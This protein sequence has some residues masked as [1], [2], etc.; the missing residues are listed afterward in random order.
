MPKGRSVKELREWVA[1]AQ[2]GDKEAFSEVVKR[3]QD[4]A[5]AIA[6]AMLDD[7]GLAQDAAQEAF[8]AAY[9]NLTALREPAAFPGWFRRIVIKHSDR[10]RRSRKPS[11][12]LDDSMEISATVPDPMRA[13]AASE[14]KNEIHN[15]IAELPAIQRQIITLFYLRDYSQKEI[16]GF[17]ELPVSTIKK[18]LFT[19]RK[20]LKG[21]LESMVETQIQ[22]NRPSQSAAFADE[23]Q[24]LLALR[25]G[26]FEGFKRMVKRQPDLLEMRF[27]A[28]VTRERHYWPLGGTVLH[29]AVVTGDEALL[30]FLLSCKVNVEPGDRDGWTPL[31]TAVWTGQQAII[32]CLLAAGAGPNATTKNGH[33][34]LHFAA[35][36]NYPEA[37]TPLLEAGARIDLADKNGRTPMD[38]AVLKN[39]QSVIDQLV[40]HGAEQVAIAPVRERCSAPA[41]PM[42]ETGIKVIDLF[43]PLVRGRHNGILTPHTNVGSLVLLTELMLRLDVLYGS[44]T[45][46]LGLDDEN[47]TSRDMQL[48]IG[49]AGINDVVSLI[50]GNV[51]DSVEQQS[52]MLEQ[53]LA[54]AYNLR[55]QGKE[56]LFLVLN[57]IDLYEAFEAR[58]A[59]TSKKDAGITTLYFCGY[60]AGAEPEPLAGLDAVIALDFGRAKQGLYPAVDPINSRSCLLQ[61][62]NVSKAQRE[63]AAEARRLLRRY[64]DLQPIIESRGIDLL[65]KD[66]DR[67]IVERANRLQRFLTQPFH[68]TEPWTNLPGVHVPL[69]ETLE[70]CRAIL[71]GECDDVPEEAFYFVGNLEA[72][73]GKAKVGKSGDVNR[74][75]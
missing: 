75:S 39:A 55:D 3:C 8:I 11:Y 26:D 54:K 68:W 53:A 31:H 33:T 69:A 63:I 74:K 62:G 70:G 4:M 2:L 15:A 23:V 47:F 18:H 64:Q 21:R 48:L 20:K 13:L 7:T 16:E 28:P 27:K 60:T 35:M 37:V 24:Y 6:Y 44:R 29:W 49:D 73:R 30:A 45:I 66:E 17:L 72:A 34:P 19:A 43:A 10:E 9:L 65:P 52:E 12:P 58:H 57:R 67:K 61:E 56:V 1:A 51:N 36:R 25:T 41:A 14:H 40:A 50:F 42:M 5:Y 59:A 71:E 22:S 46:C 38:W 32:K